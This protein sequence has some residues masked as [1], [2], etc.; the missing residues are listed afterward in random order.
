MILETIP[1]SR[2]LPTLLPSLHSPA[3]RPDIHKEGCGQSAPN[4]SIGLRQP[5]FASWALELSC[6][7]RVLP[8]PPVCFGLLIMHVLILVGGAS[9]SAARRFTHPL[10]SFLFHRC[11]AA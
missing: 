8:D 4:A 10:Y 1:V 3:D 9:S 2:D 11:A 7:L 5:A 6:G